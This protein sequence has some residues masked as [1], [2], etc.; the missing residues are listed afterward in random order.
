MVTLLETPVRVLITL[1]IATTN[2]HVG[3]QR[4]RLLVSAR[5]LTLK[6]GARVFLG[7]PV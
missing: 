3:E 4:A 2:L 5:L 7:V 1:L 6:K